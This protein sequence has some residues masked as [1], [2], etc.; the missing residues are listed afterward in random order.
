MLVS[1]L[2][3]LSTSLILYIVPPGRVAYWADWSLF[4]LSKEQWTG[5]HTNL[6]FL[7]VLSS[8]FHIC[9]NWKSIVNYL[10]NSM[11]EVRVFTREFNLALIICI[12]TV[13]GTYFEIPPF[14]T[15]LELGASFKD[16]GSDKYGEPPYGHAELSSLKIF[17]RRMGLDL[18]KAEA[19]LRDAGIKVKD[20][21]QSIKDIAADNDVTPKKIYSFIKDADKGETN[22]S[23]GKLPLTPPPGTGRIV[24]SDLCERYGLDCQSLVEK[25]KG[26]SIEASAGQNLKTIADNNAMDPHQLYDTILKITEK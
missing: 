2:A 22:Q 11:R 25:L 10:K 13:A 24:L 8:L 9:F 12:G 20:S 21:E 17:S 1:G 4:G 6:G 18:N 19:A 5:F 15:V 23:K 26:Q 3:L 7:L 14:S 16:K